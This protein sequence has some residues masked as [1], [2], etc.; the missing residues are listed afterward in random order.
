MFMVR[1]FTTRPDGVAWY[2]APEGVAETLAQWG[3]AQFATGAFTKA[4]LRKIGKNKVVKTML[5]AD[6]ASYDTW[7]E[8][9]KVHPEHIAKMA[10][11]EA[12]GIVTVT[13]K[14]LMVD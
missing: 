14:F 12:N 5:F 2:K 11:N 8:A 3:A 7:K 6:Q 13:K 1:T 9:I 10:Y 4:R